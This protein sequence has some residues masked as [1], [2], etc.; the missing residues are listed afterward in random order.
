M[1]IRCAVIGVG[2]LGRFHAQKYA[3]LPDAKLVA[4]VD[5]DK[6][7]VQEI[8]DE[9]GCSA[10]TDY[11]ELIGQV[12]A[13]SIVAPTTLHHKIASV[14]LNNGIHVLVEKP[15]TVTLEEADDLIQLAETNDC[16]LQ[17]GHLERFNAAIQALDGELDSSP[18]FI[19]SHRLAP[20]KPRATDV[21]VILDL[22][23]HDI[24]IILNLVN[25]EIKN[26]SA[27]GASVLSD[28]IDIANARLE[29]TNGCVANVTASR[30]SQKSERKMRLFLPY[31]YVGVDFQEKSV[32]LYKKGDGEM[33]PGVAEIVHQSLPCNEQ[34]ALQ[35]E[36]QSFLDTINT[37]GTPLVSG[38]DGRQALATALEINQLVP[39]YL[40][41]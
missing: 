3:T 5:A 39:S 21:D 2:Y 19:E 8:A 41:K 17:V 10:V 34:D 32:D 1:T 20:F 37:N 14:F 26:I 25:S 4:V 13:V 15:I 18:L 22:M 36:I 11:N 7:R 9:V 12:D 31:A 29:F 40:G 24:D 27:T 35:A 33:F 23:I 16:V 30:V 28:S 6:D 38:K